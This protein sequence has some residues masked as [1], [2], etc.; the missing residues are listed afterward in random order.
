MECAAPSCTLRAHALLYTQRKVE[1][2][3]SFESTMILPDSRVHVSAA[4]L[5]EVSKVAITYHA[6]HFLEYNIIYAAILVF[7]TGSCVC[8]SSVT[9]W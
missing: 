2:I 3:V 1:G 5:I 8:D 9:E 7:H 6:Q 4:R